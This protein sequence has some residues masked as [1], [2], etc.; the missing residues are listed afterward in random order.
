[1]EDSGRIRQHFEG[2]LGDPATPAQVEHAQQRLG[3][4]LPRMRLQHDR[5][6]DGFRGSTDAVFFHPLEQLVRTTL[7]LRG[8]GN[9]PTIIQ[10]AV[11]LGDHG[12]G[13]GACWPV[14]LERPD[15]VPDR[16]AQMQGEEREVLPGTPTDAWLARQAI[17]E[18]G[19]NA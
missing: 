15:A 14:H 18:D 19:D 12:I 2:P 9:F 11:A 8:E 1:M 17:H 5:T 16:Q 4:A 3:H 6:C 10:K 13:N 7:W